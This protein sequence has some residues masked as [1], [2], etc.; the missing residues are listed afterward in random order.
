MKIGELARRSGLSIDTIRWYERIGLLPTAARAASGQRDYDESILVW[1]AFL[2]R[3]KTTGMAVRDMV[4]YARWREQGDQTRDQR[5]ALLRRHR[6]A[7]RGRI[8]ELQACLG[9]LDDKIALYSGPEN[10]HD[11]D[12]G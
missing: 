7:V 10:N 12:H 9:V 3:L 8:A 4:S 6:D 11:P 2:G 5:G 1:I